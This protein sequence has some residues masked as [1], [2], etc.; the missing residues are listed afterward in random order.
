MQY[1]IYVPSY[2]L[3]CFLLCCND[4]YSRSYIQ[5]EIAPSESLIH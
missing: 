3:V 2:F 5:K 1:V 4:L